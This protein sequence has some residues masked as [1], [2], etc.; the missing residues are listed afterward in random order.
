MWDFFFSKK[1]SF[2]TVDGYLSGIKNF[3]L[4]IYPQW[5]LPNH[6]YDLNRNFFKN[7]FSNTPKRVIL[8]EG[9]R[10]KCFL[11]FSWQRAN[12]GLE[13]YMIACV[14]FACI[15]CFRISDLEK[16][17]LDRCEIFEDMLHNE[18]LFIKVQVLG[19]KNAKHSETQTIFLQINKTQEQDMLNPAYTLQLIQEWRQSIGTLGSKI[20]SIPRNIKFSPGILNKYVKTAYTKWKAV[21]EK[22]NTNL[23][24]GMSVDI[25]RKSMIKTAICEF[26]LTT[27][28]LTNLT[29]HKNTTALQRN[30][31]TH[32]STTQNKAFGNALANL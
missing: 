18:H 16:L 26:G 29:R 2:S 3:Y 15:C 24:T 31:L 7:F 9:K 11:N 14:S 6:G 22:T 8:L 23:P 1:M 5:F 10:I 25:L 20:F 19:A 28:Q 4:E 27:T 32:V 17:Q 12:R 21:K 30:Y 13:T